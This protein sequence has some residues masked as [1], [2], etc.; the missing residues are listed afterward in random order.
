MASTGSRHN[1]SQRLEIGPLAPLFVDSYAAV[2]TGVIGHAVRE[3]VSVLTGLA[4][5]ETSVWR[6]TFG[7]AGLVVVALCLPVRGNPADQRDRRPKIA[8]Q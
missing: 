7:G 6:F 4:G 2:F 3:F 5:P 1:G 8:T